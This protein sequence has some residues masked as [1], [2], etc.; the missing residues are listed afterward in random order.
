MGMCC[1]RKDNEWVMKC[2]E[3]EAEG[4]RTRGRPRGLGELCGKNCQACELSRQDAM[5]C[6]GWRKLIKDG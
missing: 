4:S 6:G 2:M 1:E 3:Y 5:D